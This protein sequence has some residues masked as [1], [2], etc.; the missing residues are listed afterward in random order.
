LNEKNRN[1]FLELYQE[2]KKREL[3]SQGISQVKENE[4]L[5]MSNLC[6]INPHSKQITNEFLKRIFI[7]LFQL[8][9]DSETNSFDCNKV[10]ADSVPEIIIL[11]LNPILIELK[12]QNETLF[13]DEFCIACKHLYN[14]IPIE[15]KHML[16]DW[17]NNL[18][19]FKKSP[20]TNYDFPFKVY[21]YLS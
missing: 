5:I 20:S 6:H 8:L 7:K 9:A 18:N 4:K 13:L 16:V 1:K 17:Y 3:K 21:F 12:D 15:Q 2:W 14:M 10:N 19:G 11:I